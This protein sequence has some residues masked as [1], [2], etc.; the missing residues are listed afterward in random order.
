MYVFIMCKG[1]Y[2]FRTK[3]LLS[4]VIQ[5]SPMCPILE[6]KTNYAHF[7]FLSHIV[8]NLKTSI[9]RAWSFLI[10]FWYLFGENFVLQWYNNTFYE[11]WLIRNVYYKDKCIIPFIICHKLR[12]FLSPLPP[13]LFETKRIDILAT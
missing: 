4:V 13:F 8:L 5:L 10:C 7:I 11:W 6:N 3:M 12:L 1:K 9:C 2:I